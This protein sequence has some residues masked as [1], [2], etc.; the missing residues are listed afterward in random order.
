MRAMVFA[1]P[2]QPLAAANVPRPEPTAG[3]ILVRAGAFRGSAVR[4]MH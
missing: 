3:R 1:R 2:G 4:L